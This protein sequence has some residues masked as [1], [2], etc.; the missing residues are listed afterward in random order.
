LKVE[1]AIG[2]ENKL[3]GTALAQKVQEIARGKLRVDGN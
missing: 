2:D 1:E 3:L